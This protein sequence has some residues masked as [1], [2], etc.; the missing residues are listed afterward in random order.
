MEGLIS[1]FFFVAFF[2]GLS[3]TLLELFIKPRD[4]ILLKF[5]LALMAVS[6]GF[7]FLMIWLA[8][9]EVERHAAYLS[10]VVMGLVFFVGA[11]VCGWF[12]YAWLKSQE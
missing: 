12:G 6:A 10:D 7:F 2:F 11:F 3:R 8:N 9:L 4:M 5:S 1:F